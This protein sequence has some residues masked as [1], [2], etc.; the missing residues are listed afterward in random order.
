MKS[1]AIV[2][3]MVASICG[4]RTCM[5]MNAPTAGGGVIIIEGS[6]DS[7]IHFHPL[8][9]QYHL[10]GTLEHFPVQ[11]TNEGQERQPD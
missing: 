1:T 8:E 11:I 10:I 4:H 7:S 5:T 2:V 3:M 9:C 6:E